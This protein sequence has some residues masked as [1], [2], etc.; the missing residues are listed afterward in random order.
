MLVSQER[1]IRPPLDTVIAS[2]R[3]K[4]HC[5]FPLLFCGLVRAMGHDPTSSLW[6]QTGGKQAP[7][8]HCQK[9]PF[10]FPHQTLHKAKNQAKGDGADSK[11][12]R[13]GG[14]PLLTLSMDQHGIHS[15]FCCALVNMA[16]HWEIRESDI[17]VS[18]GGPTRQ[19]RTEIFIYIALSNFN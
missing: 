14:G 5:H 10:S 15:P 12:R 6:V 18:D 3:D 7:A 17:A 13:G 9:H 4:D 11:Q 1:M 2:G 19:E 8:L 16:P